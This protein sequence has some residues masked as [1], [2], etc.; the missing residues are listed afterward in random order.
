MLVNVTIP[1]FNEEKRL[2]AAVPKLHRFLPESCPLSFELIIADNGSTDRTWAIAQS[3]AREYPHTQASHLDLKGRGRALK[4]AWSG[5]TAD[6]LSYMD[7]DLSADLKAFPPLIEALASGQYDLATGSRLQSNSLTVRG[8]RR[9]AAS[10]G[11]NWLVK[12]L[13]ATQFSDAQCGFKAM[14]R[15]AAT[16]LLPEVKDSGWF[17]DTEL[18]AIAEKCGFRIFDLPV[19]WSEDPDSRVRILPTAWADI[20]GLLRVRRNLQLSRYGHLGQRAQPRSQS[21]RNP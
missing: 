7:V 11:Y 20:K 3:L 10:R 8:W 6:I 19:N 18:L 14:T 13:L 12:L 4:Q 1:V 9:E 5:S 21:A 15:E 17:F 16:Q 2:V